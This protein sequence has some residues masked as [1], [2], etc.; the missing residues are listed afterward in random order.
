MCQANSIPHR[1]ANE[2]CLYLD[3]VV[4]KKVWDNR[5]SRTIKGKFESTKIYKVS[6]LANRRISAAVLVWIHGGG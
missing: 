6:G 3:V 2:D 4:P 1:V 5:A